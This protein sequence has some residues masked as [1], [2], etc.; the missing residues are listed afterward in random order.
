MFTVNSLRKLLNKVATRGDEQVG[1]EMSTTY[2]CDVGGGGLRTR[3]SKKRT[4]LLPRTIQIVVSINHFA[5]T[6]LQFK[7][8]STMFSIYNWT[9]NKKISS[10]KIYNKGYM[11]YSYKPNTHECEFV[12]LG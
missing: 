5:Y 11:K 2:L 4:S 6:H 7:F 12:F 9:T 10:Q 1:E 3:K 8:L